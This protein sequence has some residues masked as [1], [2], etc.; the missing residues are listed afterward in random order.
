MQETP[1]YPL[2]FE[3][4]YQYRLWGGR[5]L[6]AVLA[7]PLPGDDP[8]GEGWILS[9]RDDH[10]SVVA[11]GP[12]K[13]RTIRQ[14]LQRSPERVLGELSRHFR[15]FPLLLKFLDVTT[16]L[17]VQVHPSDAH[18]DLIPPGDSGK[19]EAWV[20][21]SEGPQARIYAGLKSGS[22]AQGLR[23]AVADGTVPSQLTSFAP[24]TG[25]GFFIPAGTVHSLGDVV[26]F[27]VQENSDVTFRLYDWDHRDPRTGQLRPMQADHAIACIDFQQRAMGPVTPTVQETTPILRER[28]IQCSHFGVTRIVAKSPFVVGEAET[29]RVLVCLAG[30]GQL[31][32]AGS[33]YSFGK[34][35]VL[36]VAAETGIC[37]CQPRGIVSV[38]EISVPEVA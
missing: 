29:L 27:E 9:D 7:T 10:P 19:D 3:P 8:I 11:D 36:L 6:G 24:K 33:Q 25:D 28:L 13:G 18:K 20:V 5:R 12:L 37:S 4:I 23:Q 1:L 30:N 32:H 31:A 17:S 22:C 26:V 14:L 38:L 15:R 21:L 35:D 34:G 2:R 16:R